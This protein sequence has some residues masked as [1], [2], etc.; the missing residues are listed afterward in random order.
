M[1]GLL[2]KN[3]C[4]NANCCFLCQIIHEF[5]VRRIVE[6]VQGGLVHGLHGD[7]DACVYLHGILLSAAAC[8]F[9]RHSVTRLCGCGLWRCGRRCCIDAHW[10]WWTIVGGTIYTVLASDCFLWWVKCRLCDS[11]FS[12]HSPVFVLFL[13]H[14]THQC[15]YTVYC[16]MLS[17]SICAQVITMFIG[18]TVI[19]YCHHL[20]THHITY[21]VL[22]HFHCYGFMLFSIIYTSWNVLGIVWS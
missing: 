20:V 1:Q 5:C 15:R 7:C 16:V 18:N 21:H 8:S 12:F 17:I 9:C 19:L 14:V 11:C 10:C 13:E 6:C 4:Q 2:L 22:W 3:L